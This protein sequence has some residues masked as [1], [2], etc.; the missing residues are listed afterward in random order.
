MKQ[1]LKQETKIRFLVLL[2]TCQSPN[3]SANS[4]GIKQR[5]HSVSNLDKM[6]H[7][8]EPDRLSLLCNTLDDSAQ[9][10]F[11]CFP[12][13]SVPCLALDMAIARIQSGSALFS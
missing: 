11:S 9:L 2:A 10:S 8:A 5:I 1:N 3:Y 13:F 12:F 4:C 7:W 6:L